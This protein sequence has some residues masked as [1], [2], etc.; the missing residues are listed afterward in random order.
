MRD[1][2]SMISNISG[3]SDYMSQLKTVIGNINTVELEIYRERI[4]N[5]CGYEEDYRKELA[6]IKKIN[7][8]NEQS[9]EFNDAYYI[10]KNISDIYN[11]KELAIEKF[12]KKISKKSKK[13]KTPKERERIRVGYFPKDIVKTEWWKNVKLFEKKA[14]KL[15]ETLQFDSEKTITENWEIANGILSADVNSRE[16]NSYL[17][18]KV[19]NME[20]L[21][22][23]YHL[24]TLGSN[25]ID[26][27]LL[28]FY[29]Y[30]KT[31]EKNWYIVE[32]IFKQQSIKDKIGENITPEMI[33]RMLGNFV[34]A[35]YRSDLT[36]SQ[37][38]Y[39]RLF[40]EMMDDKDLA[41]ADGARF[42][43]I[44]DAIDTDKL[45]KKQNAYKF[46]EAA[47]AVMHKLADKK[48]KSNTE[49]LINE[50]KDVLEKTM[51]N[52]DEKVEEVP[53]EI[54]ENTDIL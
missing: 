26:Q 34:V 24:K 20:M 4:N 29:D 42:L 14:N 46:A 45:D 35:K 11:I 32:K 54:N 13:N 27:I 33:M 3:H 23:L 7:D 39:M 50:I 30:Q 49:D 52:P 17:G 12:T 15:L 44:M 43:E 48:D 18:I 2:D 41:T 8:E 21:M 36:G 5:L 40:A 37:K 10:Y 9:S 16:I 6:R 28:P 53:P 1:I 31:I 47:K 19:E 22:I 51:G 38:Y 25:I